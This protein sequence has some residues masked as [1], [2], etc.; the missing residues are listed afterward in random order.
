MADVIYDLSTLPCPEYP[1]SHPK[2]K[3]TP[4]FGEVI[5]GGIFAD[6][7]FVAKTEWQYVLFQEF[8]NTNVITP[9]YIDIPLSGGRYT[10]LGKGTKVIFAGSY[11]TESTSKGFWKISAKLKIIDYSISQINPN[12]WTTSSGEAWI[13]SSSEAWTTQ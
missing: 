1:L 9:F 2:Q 4:T 3:I 12:A 11:S 13:T 7:S 6:V 5:M 10:D 8:Y